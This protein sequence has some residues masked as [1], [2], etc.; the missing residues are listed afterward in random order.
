MRPF[1]RP[2][3]DHD[4][5]MDAIG[6]GE[7]DN[8]IGIARGTEPLFGEGDGGAAR[9]DA[10]CRRCTDSSGGCGDKIRNRGVG[11]ISNG[12]ADLRRAVCDLV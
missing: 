7:S 8:V 1:E 4:S 12:N 11:R 5:G 3:V 9:D 2:P 10:R 6:S